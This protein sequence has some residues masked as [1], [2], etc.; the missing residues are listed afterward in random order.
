[1]KPALIVTANAAHARL[2]LRDGPGD[3]LRPLA[4]LEHAASRRKASGLEDDRLGHDCMDQRPGGV[5]HVP[6]TDPR[7]KEHL[8]FADEL[9]QLIDDL[10]REDGCGTLFVLA[11]D[12]FL[13]ELK[14]SLGAAAR[15]A[16]RQALPLDYTALDVG[17]LEQR[18]PHVLSPRASP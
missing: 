9:A 6:R 1:M 5:S 7:R 12:P 11:S 14:G 2:F 18:L 13:G 3:P 17:E 10:L 4:V 15:R 8:R 16:L